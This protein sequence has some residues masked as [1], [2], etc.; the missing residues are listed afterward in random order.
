MPTLASEW[1]YELNGE[2]LPSDVKLHADTV[3]YWK[4]H[5]CGGNW[6]ASANTRSTGC[7]CPYCA[8]KKVL[9]GY[10]DL[11]TKNP[12]LAKQWNYEMNSPITPKDVTTGTQ[13]KFWWTCAKGHK[14]ESDVLNRN[15]GNGCP[16]CSNQKVLSGYNDFA[17]RYPHLLKEW[18]F[19]KNTTLDPYKIIT[20]RKTK[21]W[22]KCSLCSNEWQAYVVNRQ[23]GLGCPACGKKRTKVS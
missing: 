16:Y 6:K 1:D 11:A 3:I 19:E 5:K 4:C 20:D 14:W 7:G 8:G 2:L 21:V 15:K 12:E 23:V 10:N 17:T 9:V 18:N 13:R 22:W